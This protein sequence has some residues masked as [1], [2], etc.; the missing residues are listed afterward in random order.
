MQNN[1]DN[2]VNAGFFVRLAAYVIDSVIVGIA[3]AIFVQLPIWI[4]TLAAPENFLV[5]DFIFKYSVKDIV[6]Y[7][8]GSLY[9]IVLT[10]KS[11]ET[12][13]KKV[14]HIKVVSTE[15]RKLTLF[16]VIYRETVGK[17]LSELIVCAGFFMIGIHKEKRGLHDLLADTKVIYCHKEI[18]EVETPITYQEVPKFYMPNS[19]AMPETYVGTEPVAKDVQEP[20]AHEEPEI[21]VEIEVYEDIEI[22]QTEE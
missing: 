21:E 17:F 10:Y 22:E 6:I 3:L 7:I 12:I 15:D 11:G 20:M 2:Q 19:Y 13:G 9:F 16:E 14:L 5:K 4:S 8:L 1:M 18:V